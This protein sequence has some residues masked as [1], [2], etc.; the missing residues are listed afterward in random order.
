MNLPRK[1]RRQPLV[2]ALLAT[3]AAPIRGL[4][5]QTAAL[6]A[7]GTETYQSITDVRELSNG[8]VLISD[9]EGS[10]LWQLSTDNK[11]IVA[12]KSGTIQAPGRFR[13]FGKDSTLVFS[14]A[15]TQFMLLTPDGALTPAPSSLKPPEGPFRM[16]SMQDLY[17]TNG[18]GDLFWATPARDVEGMPLQRRKADGTTTT[19]TS[20]RMPPSRRGGEGGIVYTISVPFTP[21][22]E[23]EIADNGDVVVARGE[24]YRIDRI[25][26]D[27]T[28]TTGKSRDYTGVPLTSADREQVSRDRQ[29]SMGSINV[30]GM[31]VNTSVPDDAWPKTKPA[32]GRSSV[33]VAQD[34]SVWVKR[35]VAADSPTTQYDVFNSD[36][37][38]RDAVTLPANANVV[39]FGKGVAY[40]SVRAPGA[41]HYQLHTLARP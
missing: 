4:H 39:G 14:R 33:R 30:G 7:R 13:A 41:E 32:F 12:V 10:A 1:I 2:L 15:N 6:T 9:T 3:V 18:H 28:I 34:G 16:G 8:Q 5:A 22:D 11:R 31:T 21:V 23:W 40:V 26:N 25:L 37:G 27:G 17:V 20:L 35:H 24:P 29:K 36:G 19:L 38:F